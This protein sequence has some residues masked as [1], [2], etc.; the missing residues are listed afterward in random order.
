MNFNEIKELISIIDNSSLKEF[1][2]KI[3]NAVISMSKS[4]TGVEVCNTTTPKSPPVSLEHTAVSKAPITIIPK[5]EVL[6][7]EGNI[8][9][10]P[11][12]GMFYDRPSPEKKAF[13]SVG[14][15][16]EVGDILCIIEA[17][18]VMNEITSKFSGILEEV[19]VNNEQ[20]VEFSQPLFR[21]V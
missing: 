20:E 13:K 15:K 14:D 3:D 12:V 7:K 2:I 5:E 4:A 17:M 19:M 9:T 21:I 6:K 11:I 10:A 1:T 8:V 16:V 18:K